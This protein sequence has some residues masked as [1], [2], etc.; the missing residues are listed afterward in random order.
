MGLFNWLFGKAAE[1]ISD[2]EYGK[3]KTA[4]AP[5]RNPAIQGHAS[6]C[7]VNNLPAYPPEPC[8]C[9]VDGH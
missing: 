4:F 8:D 5:N 9:G 3:G 7:A 2:R 1:K 6:D